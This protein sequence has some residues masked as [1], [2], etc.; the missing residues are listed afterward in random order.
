VPIPELPCDALL[1]FAFSQPI[2][3]VKSFAGMVFLVTMRN[4]WVEIS[5]IGSK[6]FSRSYGSV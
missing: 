5:A 6:S 3:S 2:N 1:A 4:G